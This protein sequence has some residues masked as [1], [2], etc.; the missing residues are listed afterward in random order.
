VAGL[1]PITSLSREGVDVAVEWQDS[2]GNP[3]NTKSFV[4]GEAYRAV[5]VLKAKSGY[6]FDPD[7]GFDYRSN[8]VT[9]K[10]ISRPLEALNRAVDDSESISVYVQGVEAEY[11]PAKTPEEDS[12]VVIDYNLQD[13]VPI[14]VADW[15]PVK[16]IVN[17]KG[18]TGSVVWKNSTGETIDLPGFKFAMGEIYKADITLVT[19]G[20]YVFDEGIP[21]RYPQGSVASQPD[22]A[23]LDPHERVVSVTYN[24]TDDATAVTKYDL[25]PYIPAPVAGEYPVPYITVVD[26]DANLASPSQYSGLV[27]WSPRHAVFQEKV[28]Y[29]ATVFLYAGPGRFFSTYSTFYHTGGAY[30]NHPSS[31]VY[32]SLG[33]NFP[34]AGKGITGSDPDPGDESADIEVP[35]Y[36]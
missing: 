15:E 33:I 12:N 6:V 4:R 30:L 14:P 1:A 23:V 7:V 36:L 32:R 28:E 35:V 3:M 25:T 18:V 16:N 31:K 20:A 22:Q 27:L 17:R 2:A 34:P 21:F 11:P 13:Y 8:L 24:P 19:T 10:P 26:D 5:I 29:K 9:V